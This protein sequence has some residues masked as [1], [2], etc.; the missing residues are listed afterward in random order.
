[1]PPSLFF[2]FFFFFIKF[3]FKLV[4]FDKE[5]GLFGVHIIKRFTVKIFK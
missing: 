2:F 4:S 5:S 3:I 1:L